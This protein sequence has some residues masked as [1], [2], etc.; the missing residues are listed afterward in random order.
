MGGSSA[1]ALSSLSSS[2]S[3]PRAP[4]AI[5]GD[6][7]LTSPHRVTTFVT[8]VEQLKCLLQVKGVMGSED[9][10]ELGSLEAFEACDDEELEC[11][12][13]LCVDCFSAL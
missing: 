11:R 6:E 12:T 4:S 3:N 5:A 2:I 9:N 7:E 13:G 1:P 10:K 8:E